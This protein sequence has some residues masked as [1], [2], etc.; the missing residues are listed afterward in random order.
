M[1]VDRKHKVGIMN[2]ETQNSSSGTLT[3]LGAAVKRVLAPFSLGEA[4]V[5]ADQVGRIR[6]VP[7]QAVRDHVG[8]R[9]L[10]QR[11]NRG[12]DARA[13][14]STGTRLERVGADLDELTEVSFSAQETISFKGLG[15]V[16]RDKR[17]SPALRIEGVP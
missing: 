3:P 1:L 9:A 4:I 11:E 2:D 10:E 15:K 13:K 7:G 17:S 6:V 14:L 8:A 5:T 16:A 12:A